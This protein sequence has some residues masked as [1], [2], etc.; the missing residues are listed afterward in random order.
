MQKPRVL[1]LNNLNFIRKN[2]VGKEDNDSE[3]LHEAMINAYLLIVGE[4][5]YEELIENGS[6][7]WLP[8]G[9]D[10]KMS[11]DTVISYFEQESIQDYEKCADMLKVKN[12]L[13][14]LGKNDRLQDIYKKIEW[15]I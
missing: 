6:E 3:L 10:E 7:L 2:I 8:S 15:G 9:F 5:T 11:I 14:K 1:L 12:A 13:K 4:L